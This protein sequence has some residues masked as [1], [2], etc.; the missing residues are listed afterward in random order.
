[1]AILKR[2]ELI[3]AGKV[4]EILSKED[5]VEV[6]AKD[7]QKLLEVL[8][9][10]PEKSKVV[11]ENNVVKVF[12]PVGKADLSELNNYCFNHGVTLNHLTLKKQSLESRFFE[13]TNN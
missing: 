12:F 8:N 9:N 13:L 4:N 2:G 7:H 6:A 10:L 11:D 1:V 5:L 3:V